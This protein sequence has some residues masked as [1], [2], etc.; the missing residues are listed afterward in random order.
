MSVAAL[1]A[2]YCR[3]LAELRKREVIRSNNAPAGDYAE[4]LTARALTGELVKNFS[5]KSYDLTAGS[6]ELVQ[7]KTRVVSDPPTRG[8]L[9]T[10]PFRSWEFD[11]AAFVLLRNHDYFVVRASLVP[12]DVAKENSRFT[13]HVNGHIVHMTPN[14]MGHPTARD[15]TAALRS[16][17]LTAE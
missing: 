16:A 10:S 6:G 2:S 13:A 17:A 12:R 11:L 8:Q 15:I 7:V 3:L 5:V 1:L 4:W 14:L 9:Q